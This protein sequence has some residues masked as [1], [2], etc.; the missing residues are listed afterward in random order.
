M[1]TI[2]FGD[3]IGYKAGILIQKRAECDFKSKFLKAKQNADTNSN[4]MIKAASYYTLYLFYHHGWGEVLK[5]D[6]LALKHLMSSMSLGYPV[7]GMDLARHYLKEQNFS[8]A[9]DC[10]QKCDKEFFK[11][12][13]C[14]QEKYKEE[15][16]DMMQLLKVITS[17]TNNT[18]DLSDEESVGSEQEYCSD[19]YSS[20]P[21]SRFNKVPLL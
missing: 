5:N 16:H 6:S 10:I 18:E 19:I 21:K 7:A 8:K 12:D 20:P 17:V 15:H 13:H 4:L 2:R 11:R 1:K 3:E 9:E 14:E